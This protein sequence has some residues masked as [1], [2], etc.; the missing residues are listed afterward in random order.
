MQVAGDK[1]VVG[2]GSSGEVYVFG[3]EAGP[4][5]AKWGPGGKEQEKAEWKCLDKLWTSVQFPQGQSASAE[6]AM[7]LG[8]GSLGFPSIG[9]PV[10][11]LSGRWLAYCPASTGTLTAG[12]HVGVPI[13]SHSVQA[14]APPS[15]PPISAACSLEDEAF[16][17]R[18]AREVTQEV[19]RGAKWAADAGFKKFQSYMHGGALGG[20]SP[21]LPHQMPVGMGMPQSDGMQ[22]AQIGNPQQPSGLGQQLRQLQQMGGSPQQ[23]QQ[24]PA[25]AQYAYEPQLVSVVDLHKENGLPIATFLPPAGVSFLSFAPGGLSLLTASSKGDILFVWDLLKVVHHPPGSL[26]H[27]RSASASGMSDTS[28]GAH[29]PDA[30]GKHVRQVARFTRM[31][32]ATIVDVDWSSPRGEKIAVITEKGTAH[33]YDLP[34]AALQWPPPR[35][36]PPSSIAAHGQTTSAGAVVSNAVDLFNSSTRP[37]LTAA[38][39]RRSRSSSVGSPGGGGMFG[40][41]SVGRRTSGAP[42]TSPNAPGGN[43]IPLP[44]S[45]S[46]I[47]PGCVKFLTAKER[48]FV[49]VIGGGLLRIYELR[50]GGS[51]KKGSTT[52]GVASGNWWEYDLPNVPATSEHT[53]TEPSDGKASGFWAFRSHWGRGTDEDNNTDGFWKTP[54]AWAEIETNSA[55]IPWHQERRVKMFVYDPPTYHKHLRPPGIRVIPPPPNCETDDTTTEC[56]N[57][58]ENYEKTPPS[59]PPYLEPSELPPPCDALAEIPVTEPAPVVDPPQAPKEKWVFG[60]PMK[61][62]RIFLSD[63]GGRGDVT[64][65]GDGEVGLEAAMMD[66]LQLDVASGVEEG[67]FEEWLVLE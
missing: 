57:K 21:P 53:F 49:A 32:V 58:G 30:L 23:F 37:L 22:V 29:A 34:Y 6:A 45:T 2:V 61:A 5:G 11:A 31:T 9:T 40:S 60:M 18:M 1:I 41:P 25:Q 38:R 51:G 16:L 65:S 28:G 27:H 13:V 52:G 50:P 8:L 19:I 64:F 20:N 46:G 35:R 66:G 7:G 39:R 59:P 3:A 43:K 12:G 26:N 14:P 56:R 63:A 42:G 44:P 4:S 62:E 24:Q 55:F 67:F 10:F 47:Y 36:P 33:F 48:G 54:L 17:N 15:Q